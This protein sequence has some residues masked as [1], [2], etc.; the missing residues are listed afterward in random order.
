MK[1][2]GREKEKKSFQK[3]QKIKIIETKKIRNKTEMKQL[4]K[5]KNKK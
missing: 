1:I 5:F 3:N 2:N 4:E